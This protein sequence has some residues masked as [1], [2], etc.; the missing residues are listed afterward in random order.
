[1]RRLRRT[2]S[3]P[4][5][6]RTTKQP[7]VNVNTGRPGACRRAVEKANDAWIAASA[8]VETTELELENILRDL[9]RFAD[10]EGVAR[11]LVRAE[12]QFRAALKAEKRAQEKVELALLAELEAHGERGEPGAMLSTRPA[13]RPASRP[14]RAK[15]SQRSQTAPARGKTAERRA[16]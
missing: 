1:M 6:G 14:Q 4:A 3:Q 13:V 7:V 11:E 8:V 12:A 10:Q 9:A 2:S 15:R 5:R 16:G